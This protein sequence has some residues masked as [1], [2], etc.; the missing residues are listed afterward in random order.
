MN[1]T[2]KLKN[3]HPSIFC[4][5]LSPEPNQANVGHCTPWIGRQPVAGPHNSKFSF[6]VIIPQF[7]SCDRC[8]VSEGTRS[9]T[10]LT[11]YWSKIF[12]CFSKVHKKTFPAWSKT[13]HFW[14]LTN[15]LEYPCFYA[16]T[17]GIWNDS[18]KETNST[19]IEISFCSFFPTMGHWCFFNDTNGKTLIC[20]NLFICH[21]F[22]CL[23]TIWK[24]SDRN[25]VERTSITLWLILSCFSYPVWSFFLMELAQQFVYIW[26]YVC[27]CVIYKWKIQ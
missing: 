1:K 16:A 27:L 15:N 21:L 17:T 12:D 9:H 23:G 24:W 10:S 7:L 19:R 6:T 22:K 26:A 4:P 14:I 2:K 8:K 18:G 5:F 11:G 20:K 13:C 3:F 25:K